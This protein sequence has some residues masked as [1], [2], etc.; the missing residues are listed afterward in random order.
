MQSAALFT[1]YLKLPSNSDMQWASQSPQIPSSEQDMIFLRLQ[2]KLTLNSSLQLKP[3]KVLVALVVP[4]VSDSSRASGD[5]TLMQLTLTDCGNAKI[6][7]AKKAA[8]TNV[9]LNG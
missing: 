9:L 3:V 6:A 7:N 5:S 1:G 8:I 4:V 2:Q